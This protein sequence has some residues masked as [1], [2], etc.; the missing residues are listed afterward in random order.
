MPTPPLKILHVSH[1]LNTGG[2]ERIIL[3][4]VRCGPEHGFTCAVA[5]LGHGGDLAEQVEEQGG[6]WYRLD[7]REGLDWRAGFRLARLAKRWGA[8]VLHAHNEGAG[9]YAGLAGRLGSRPAICT[10]HGLSFGA[11][12]RGGWLRRAAGLLCK[13]TVCVGRDVLRFAREEDR[14]PASRLALVYNGVDTQVFQPDPEARA[15]WRKELGLGANQTVLISVGR[16]APEKDYDLLLDAM[17][18]LPSGQS[19]AMLILVGDGPERIALELKAAKLGLA[20][21]VLLL[22]ARTEVPGLLNA[23][24]LFALSSLTEG[25]PMAL[26]EAMACTLPVAALEVG[27]IPEVVEDGRS[28]VLVRGRRPEDLADAVAGVLADSQAVHSMGLAGRA[29]VLER[30]SLGAM[31]GAYASLY[32]KLARKEA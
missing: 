6:H 25:I 11:G 15:L 18:C 5:T 28:G 7:K 27:G 32:R 12:P 20:D 14:L 19:E 26:L 21:R 29:R 8:D 3:E 4:M 2:L 22:G 10:R 1:S 13:R 30:F 9:L 31:L 24:D 16:L 17:A 23:A